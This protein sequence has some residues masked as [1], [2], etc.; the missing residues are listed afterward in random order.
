MLNAA[1]GA[2]RP[3]EEKTEDVETAKK[4]RGGRAAKGKAKAKAAVAA[5][6]KDVKDETHKDADQ[7]PNDETPKDETPKD[8]TPK[9]ETPKDARPSD[10]HI[11]TKKTRRAPTDPSILMQIIFKSF[12]GFTNINI[13]LETNFQSSNSGLL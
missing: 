1:R 12:G 3:N 11:P 6:G 10:G 5:T 2:K 7:T 8:E 9:D 13:L 4:P